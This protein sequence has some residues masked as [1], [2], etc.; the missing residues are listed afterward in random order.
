M[1]N[2]NST[3]VVSEQTVALIIAVGETANVT[4]IISESV[5]YAKKTDF[6][7]HTAAKNPHGTTK[8]DIGLGNVPNVSTND[9]TVTYSVP[10]A[11]GELVSGEKMSTAFGKI[12]KAVKSLIAHISDKNNPHGI[13]ASDIGAADEEHSHSAADISSGT[14][15][16]LRGG[17]V[18][19]PG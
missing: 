15:S 12:A 10:A 11:N 3:D 9:Q 19:L 18:N 8:S 16:V 13:E 14:L 6:E 7:N 2:A 1:L 5:L 4:A 17:T